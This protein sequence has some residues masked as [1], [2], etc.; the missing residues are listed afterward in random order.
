MVERSSHTVQADGLLVLITLIWGS[1]FLLV[2][3]A[4]QSYSV[5]AF[6]FL[7]FALGSIV[8]LLLLGRRLRSL[9]P[10][11]WV[12]GIAIG[13]FL[14]GGYTLQTLGLLYT[15][16][17]KAG[18][19][20][21]LSVVIVPALSATLLRRLPDKYA[22]LGV[23]LSTVGLALL[24]LGHDLRPTLGDVLV[25]GGA[26]CFAAHIVAVSRFAPRTDALALTVVQ[27]AAVTVFSGL[28]TI[29][30]GE[31]QPPSQPVLT[32]A[33]FTGMLATALAFAVQNSVQAWTTATH[34]ALIFATEPVFAGIFGYWFGEERLARGAVIGCILILLGMLVAE[35][36]LPA[37]QRSTT[38]GG[39]VT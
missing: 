7:R 23:V 13:F 8:L 28:A 12:A 20:T 18:F 19:I 34:T 9:S 17:S 39:E 4:V 3:R 5:F 22:L 21:G 37:P 35:L 6:L 11:M 32:A 27:V 16:S 36:G 15:T 1:T 10:R 29:L 2:Q 14:F 26:F 38:P 31:W 30:L 24:T 25:L 33:A